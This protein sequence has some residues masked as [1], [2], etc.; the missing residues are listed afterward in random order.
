MTLP[1]DLAGLKDAGK[2][3]LIL[4]QAETIQRQSGQIALLLRRVAELEA[5]IGGPPKT[6]GNSSIPPSKGE[7]ANR[8]ERRAKGPRKG[9]PGVSRALAADPE[10]VV[11]AFATACPH[12]DAALAAEDQADFSAYDHIE[13]PPIVPV[14]TRVQRHRG[15]CP[16]C[17][18][19]FSAP[20]PAD[21]PPGSPFGPGI[22][23]LIMHLH[24]TQMIGFERLSKLMAE[25]FGLSISE[26]A[27]ANIIARAA[28]RLSAEADAIAERVR[29]SAV[30]ASDETSAR[31]RGKTWWQWVMSSSAGVYH[32][33]ADSRAASVVTSF[34]EG[35][36][37]EVWVADRYAAQ[38]NHAR[39]RQVCL[40]HLLR[41]AQ[42]AIDAGDTGFAPAF[43][44]LLQRACGIAAR[45]DQLTDA[46]LASYRSD[47]ERKLSRM[48]AA[49]P[50]SP[51]GRKLVKAIK[52]CRA[53]LFVFL[54]RRD[55]P[56]TNNVSERALRPSV[57][58]RKV[59]GGFRSEWG[60]AAYAAA[61]TVIATGKLQQ[62]S[63]LH[64]LRQAL[65]QPLPAPS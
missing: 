9:R 52:R 3:A 8:A 5:R 13:L 51:A 45:R 62:H 39:Q 38:D 26:G 4:A 42:Y 7:K 37:P 2:D 56:C 17:R 48:L 18:R 20:P 63:A 44:T 43:H 25:V 19:S 12:C 1:P 32:V 29:T 58:F 55:V 33:I 21:M 41:D 59:T 60:A 16:C 46:T 65:A 31:V 64:A 57:I 10:K 61:A 23:A 53:D 40:A 35:A 15:R 49:E 14:V 6:P 27:L 54:A 28:P 30:V 47:I 34:L 22:G 11:D 50:T 24:V 36:T